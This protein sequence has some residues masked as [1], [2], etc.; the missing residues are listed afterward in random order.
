MSLSPRKRKRP[1]IDDIEDDGS[2]APLSKRVKTAER[3]DAPADA[4]D[5]TAALKRAIESARRVLH[6]SKPPEKIMC[7][8]EEE[9]FLRSF[10]DSCM[11]SGRGN[12]LYISGNPGTGM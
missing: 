3:E 1:S 4:D 10:F 2:S 5:T 9:E 6:P 7:R 11:T 12:S 8:Q